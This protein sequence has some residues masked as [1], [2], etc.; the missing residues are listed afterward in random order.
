MS[1]G[2]GARLGIAQARALQ[3]RW[4]AAIER[5]DRWVEPRCVVGVDVGFEARGQIT[6]GAA[7]RFDVPSRTAREAVLARG[8]TGFP[9]V[10]GL[11]SFREAPA[12]LA[13]LSAME[14]VPDCLICDG[15]GIAHPRRFGI[16]CH[17]GLALD[18]PS[19]G[20]AKSIRVGQAQTPPDVRGA[21][22][23]LVDQGD[24]IGAALRTRVG[25]KPVYVSV[26]HRVSLQTALDWV[27]AWVTRYRLPD[28]VRL[29]DR[30][31]SR[32][33]EVP[34][35]VREVF[36]GQHPVSADGAFC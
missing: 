20:V 34:F 9:Y 12:L 15:Q 19:I 17:L 18:C 10:P 2:E 5:E 7:V 16:A 32:R 24:V 31:A 26:G 36:F 11:L 30:M 33:G 4:A 22:T 23:P 6:R 29:A 8:P 14:A 21:W 25:V 28:P 3:T 13:A 27:M 35:A 1:D